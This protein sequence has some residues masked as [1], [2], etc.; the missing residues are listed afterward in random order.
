MHPRFA[1]LV[2]PWLIAACAQ[3]PSTRALPNASSRGVS[4]PSATASASQ[5]TP[6]Q[7]RAVISGPASA[8][9]DALEIRVSLKNIGTQVVKLREA[10]L[11]SAVLVLEVENERGEHVPTVPPPVPAAES[12]DRTIEPSETIELTYQLSIFSPPLPSGRYSVRV[13]LAGVSGDP[14]TFEIRSPREL[15]S[16]RSSL[17]KA[18]VSLELPAKERSD[19]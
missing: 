15:A 9:S 8:P 2:V 19:H 16:Q 4:V 10:V 13:R 11:A 5:P 7:L 17:P 1:A 3:P 12:R 6:A 18:D 14:F